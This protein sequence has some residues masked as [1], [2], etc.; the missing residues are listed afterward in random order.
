[1]GRGWIWRWF[2]VAAEKSDGVAFDQ[3]SLAVWAG[4]VVY[5]EPQERHGT[6][7]LA[8]LR[9]QASFYLLD[10][11]SRR[12]ELSHRRPTV[13][14]DALRWRKLLVTTA[15]QRNSDEQAEDRAS[16]IAPLVAHSPS[17]AGES[18]PKCACA[19][20]CERMCSDAHHPDSIT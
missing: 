2:E 15:H 12:A 1:M 16:M 4:S 10:L 11:G 9:F 17:V 14:A 13:A 5:C 19:A 6:D 8:D 7:G 3:S 20:L 18:P